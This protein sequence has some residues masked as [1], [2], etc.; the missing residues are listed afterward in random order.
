ML[1]ASSFTET[2]KTFLVCVQQELVRDVNDTLGVSFRPYTEK[3][4]FRQCPF[5]AAMASEWPRQFA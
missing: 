5:V 3:R 2:H 4:D 1:N